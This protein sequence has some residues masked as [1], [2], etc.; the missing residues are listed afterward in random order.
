MDEIYSTIPDPRMPPGIL[1][2]YLS[3]NEGTLDIFNHNTILFSD[4][5][6]KF[7]DPFDCRLPFSFDA[8]FEEIVNYYV[9]LAHK[10]GQYEL[11]IREIN[12]RAAEFLHHMQMKDEAWNTMRDNLT[13]MLTTVRTEEGRPVRIGVLSLTEE[14][15]NILM[16]SH[17][18]DSHKGV[19]IGLRINEHLDYF[20]DGTKQKRFLRHVN[21]IGHYNPPNFFKQ[22]HEENIVWKFFTKSNQWEYEK[23]WR[24]VCWGGS[25]I[26]PMPH[27]MLRKVIYGCSTEDATKRRIEKALKNRK[28]VEF[29]QSR[30]VAN[31]IGIEIVPL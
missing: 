3:I 19:C 4:P 17:Y 24:V 16:Y 21:Y 7:N 15:E 9:R 5:I 20:Y 12:Q 10:F 1:Y 14:T 29:F 31:R 22:N 6:E 23:E 2:K 28:D 18:A 27:G 11:S 13:E 25:G 30:K 26:Y 8:T